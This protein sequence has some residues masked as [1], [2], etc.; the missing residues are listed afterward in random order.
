MY[1]LLL[2]SAPAQKRREA[3]SAA[4]GLRDDPFTI[5]STFRERLLQIFHAVVNV[6]GN[7]LV[8]SGPVL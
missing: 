6:F 4:A 2:H 3:L 1:F 7:K 8:L 5:L